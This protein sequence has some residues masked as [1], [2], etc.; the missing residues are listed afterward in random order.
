MSQPKRSKAPAPATEPAA[1]PCDCRNE[2]AA[3]VPQ[4]VARVREIGLKDPDERTF[5]YLNCF[6]HRR[7]CV[8]CGTPAIESSTPPTSESNEPLEPAEG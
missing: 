3:R 8:I 1:P 7:H 5:T 2:Y 6:D 4:I